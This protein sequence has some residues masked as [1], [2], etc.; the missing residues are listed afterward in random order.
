[1]RPQDTSGGFLQGLQQ[2]FSIWTPLN[3]PWSSVENDLSQVRVFWEHL[4]PLSSEFPV[5]AVQI[6]I[7]AQAVLPYLEQQGAGPQKGESPLVCR[8]V[9]TQSKFL[10]W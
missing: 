7:F 5:G 1:M 3:T 8:S 9:C 6:Q 10:V 4:S 2:A